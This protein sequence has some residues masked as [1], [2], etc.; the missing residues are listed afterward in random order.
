MISPTIDSL[1]TFLH[2]LA[3]AVW[4]GGQIV[5]AGIVPALQ[6]VAP[7]S[8]S[9][10]AQQ[11][12]RLAWP[13]MI[14]VIFT[15]VWGMGSVNVTDRSSD[16]LVTFAIKMALV[17]VAIIATIIHSAGT[18][19]AAKGIGGAVGL[20]TSLFAAYGGVLMAHVG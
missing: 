17:G 8:L 19:K 1:R 6:K 13:A 15:G 2:L 9:V 5:L 14:I 18:S 11:F 3:V 7:T 20:L 12:A 4:L 10:V 16:Y